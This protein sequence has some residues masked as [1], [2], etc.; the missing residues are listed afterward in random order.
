MGDKDTWDEMSLYLVTDNMACGG[1]K[2]S[3]MLYVRCDN[4][5]PSCGE[6]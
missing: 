3:N 4:Y 1:H 6:P 5:H 2:K